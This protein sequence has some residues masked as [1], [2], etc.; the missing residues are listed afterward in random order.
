MRDV[1]YA[2]IEAAEAH[3]A[4]ESGEPP[5]LVDVR[6]VSETEAMR[7]EG[8]LNLPLSRLRDL[9]GQLDRTRAVI[10]LCRSGNRATS[11]AS[12]LRELGHR[13]VLVIRGGLDAWVKSGKPVVRGVGRVWSLERQVRCAAGSLVAL[14]SVLAYA[15]DVRWLALPAVVGA[16]LVFAAVTDTCGMALILARMPWNQGSRGR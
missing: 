2:L 16:G 6:E 5:Q 7:V 14:G 10:L 8:A 3:R 9:A 12:Q 1:S 11:A 15:V 4:L 13:D